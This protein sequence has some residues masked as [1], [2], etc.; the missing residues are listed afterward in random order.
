LNVRILNRCRTKYNSRDIKMFTLIKRELIDNIALLLLAA[1]VPAII[2]TIVIKGVLEGVAYLPIGIPVIM[3]RILWPYLLCGAFVAAGCGAAQMNDDSQRKLST[4]LSVLATTRGRIFIARTVL[5]VMLILIMFVPLVVT[6][7]V[8]LKIFARPVP[9]DMNFLIRSFA[10]I[11]ATFVCCYAIGLQ[12][13]WRSSKLMAIL[14]GVA[15]SAALI[16]VVAIK[17]FGVESIIILVLFTVASLIWTW[18]KFLS[19]PL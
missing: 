9:L 8:L 12:V 2:I 4:F 13:G 6:D 11:L 3:V 14:F 19:L 1:I 5:G 15:L 16:L 10:T 7:V 17:G 18:H